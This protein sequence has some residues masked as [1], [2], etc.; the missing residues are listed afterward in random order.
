MLL[1]LE[2]ASHSYSYYCS[3]S[4]FSSWYTIFLSLQNQPLQWEDGSPYTYQNWLLKASTLSSATFIK[5]Y[6]KADGVKYWTRELRDAFRT[7]HPSNISNHNCTA[8]FLLNKYTPLWIKVPCELRMGYSKII[9]QHQQDTANASI[10]PLVISRSRRECPLGWL[11]A[12]GHCHIILKFA[13]GLSIEKGLV[14]EFCN[15]FEDSRLAGLEHL[16]YL[17]LYF[18]IILGEKSI[19]YL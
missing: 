15:N 11:F 9:C 8:M 1:L 14:A 12:Q 3:C 10:K 17:K 16:D 13:S 19:E 7:P 6:L 4:C 2:F 18:T 5:P